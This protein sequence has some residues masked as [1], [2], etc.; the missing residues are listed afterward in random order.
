MKVESTIDLEIL[1]I[2]FSGFHIDSIIRLD[3]MLFLLYRTD[4]FSDI[5]K[6]MFEDDGHGIPYKF[7]PFTYT[8]PDD[9][10]AM[11]S[12]SMVN[13][14]IDSIKMTSAFRV[15]LSARAF[16]ISRIQKVAIEMIASLCNSM[17][18]EELLKF[19]YYGPLR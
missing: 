15:F 5:F 3:K 4:L 10:E 14:V 6:E 8:L 19:C 16:C 9:L 2:A 7:G 18:L 12:E 11:K 17:S 13:L 1:L